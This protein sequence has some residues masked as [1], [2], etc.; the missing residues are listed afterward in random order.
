[1]RVPEQIIYTPSRRRFLQGVGILGGMLAASPVWAAS[2]VNLD[3]LAGGPDRRDLTTAFPQKGQMILQRTRPPLLETPFEIFD[4]GVFTPDDQFYV[5]WHWAVI[6]EEVNVATFRV[7]IRGHVNRALSLSM[8]DIMEMRRIELAAVNQC[9]GNSRGMFQPGVAGAQWENGA[10]GNALWTGIRLRDVLDRAGV[11]AGA[12][13]VRFKGLDKPVME[14]APHFMKSLDIDHARDGE[15]MLA[16]QMNGE[17]LPLLNGFPMRLI[18]PGWYA[19]YWVKMLTDIEVLDAPDENYWMKTAYRIPDTPYA[20]VKPGET[21]FKTVPINRMVP[22]SFFTNVT[23]ITIV[24]AGAAVPVRGIAFG[25]DSGVARVEISTD[26]HG[27]RKTELG[28]DEGTYGFRR[29]SRRVEAPQS[30]MLTLQVRCTNTKGEVQ[31]AE[32]N[33]NG[34]GF[35]R[36]VIEQ[37]HLRVA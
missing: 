31:P 25:G 23:D 13:A 17:Q 33:W 27:W 16:Y 1:M 12:V 29:W 18:V 8:A 20:S 22:R 10:M 26:G 28:P 9:S 6:P 15:V 2:V 19:T 4:H 37:V 36:N 14:G 5:R 3:L 24:E 7:A 35:M 21:G 30:G 34:N 32:P 11:K